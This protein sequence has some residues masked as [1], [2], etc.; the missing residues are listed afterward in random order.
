[1][2]RRDERIPGGGGKQ[3]L[4]VF[5]TVRASRDGLYLF[6]EVRSSWIVC[7]SGGEI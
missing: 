3:G 5:L 4:S 7:R 6:L 2:Q 1:M